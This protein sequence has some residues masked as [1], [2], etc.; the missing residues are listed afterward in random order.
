MKRRYLPKES[1]QQVWLFFSEILQ[2]IGN[3][4][5]LN[6]YFIRT[7]EQV[8]RICYLKTPN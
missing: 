4:V 3:N 1:D 6:I 7:G 8:K 5:I 2:T